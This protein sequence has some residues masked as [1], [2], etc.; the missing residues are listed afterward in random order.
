MQTNASLWSQTTILDS[1]V[2]KIKESDE[3]AAFCSWA[4]GRM[5]CKPIKKET[6][7][8]FG[9]FCSCFQSEINPFRNSLECVLQFMHAHFVFSSILFYCSIFVHMMNTHLICI[10]LTIAR[11]RG[12]ESPINI[13]IHII[14]THVCFV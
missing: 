13:R 3:Y 5:K 2:E 10:L 4:K 12:T 1:R 7:K 6:N 11:G 8:Q 9:M 14:W